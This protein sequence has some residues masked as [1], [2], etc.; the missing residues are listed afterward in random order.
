M[1]I[2]DR[3]DFSSRELVIVEALRE[4]LSS[5]FDK[6][7]IIERWDSGGSTIKVECQNKDNE[8]FILQLLVSEELNSLNLTNILM[9]FSMAHKGIGTNLVTAIMNT[10]KEVG[11]DLFITGFA[12]E[13]W[14]DNL[15]K[16]GAISYESGSVLI[17]QGAW[18]FN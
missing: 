10:S 3:E 7:K 4:H 8:L 11:L 2:F 12:N 17:E 16:N 14:R 13:R 1:I 6:G 15:I 5:I 9:P 18:K